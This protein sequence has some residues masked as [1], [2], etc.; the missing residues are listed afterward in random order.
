[1]PCMPMPPPIP[2]IPRPIMPPMPMVI[3]KRLR[4][5]AWEASR[6]SRGMRRAGPE[7]LLVV[8]GDEKEA[9]E[10]GVD[11]LRRTTMHVRVIPEGRRR[12]ADGE[13]RPPCGAGADH[14]VGT[15]IEFP[16]NEQA[17]PMDGRI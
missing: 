7:G 16:R 8:I 6:R 12:L 3:T 2:P 17:M 5:T 1:M 11:L 10:T 14:L 15:T 13:H 9:C 4:R